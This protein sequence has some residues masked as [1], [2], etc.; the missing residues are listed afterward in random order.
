MYEL[1][2]FGH[3][4]ETEALIKK[5]EPRQGMDLAEK[6][7]LDWNE[8]TKKWN[9]R[10]PLNA[11]DIV[12]GLGENVRGINKRGWEYVSENVDDWSITE[13]RRNLYSAHNF[14][15]VDAKH[16][17]G[18]FVD[19]PEIVR[20]DISYTRQDEMVIEFKDNTDVL[21]ITGA[22]PKEIAREFR[23]LIGPSWLPPLFGFGYGQSRWEYTT[24]EDFEE[25]ANR[26]DEHQL[27]VDMI[28]M[29]IDYM[30]HYKDF[31]LNSSFSDFK[32][33]VDSF[34]QRKL[35]LIPII[36]AGIKQEE[37]YSVYEEGVKNNYFIKNAD[38]QS[39][40][41]GAA[42]PGYALFPDFFNAEASKWFGH[43]YKILTDAGI[44]GFW[45]DMNEPALFYSKEGMDDL[46]AWLKEF[47][48]NGPE[49]YEMFALDR[50]VSSI[51]NTPKDYER[52]FHRVN[53]EWVC[54]DR[55]HNLYGTKMTQSAA[56]A[57][58]Q[59]R[60]DERTLLFS[61]SSYI[62]MHR[63][64]GIWT[65]DNSSWWSHILLILQQLPGLSMC[66]FLYSGC[67]LGGHVKDCTRDLLLRF[68]QL[69]VFTPLMRNH[70]SGQTQRQ[71]PYQFE[72]IEDFRH[73][74]E[75]RYRLIPWLYSEFLKARTNNALLFSPLS[76]VWEDL[77]FACQVEDQLMIGEEVMIA[78]V[79]TQNAKG[80]MVWLPEEMRK[81]VMKSDGSI[82]QVLMEAG[83]HYV[84]YGLDELV[85][86]LRK[87]A[88]LPLAAPVCRTADLDLNT[89][90]LIGAP[91][92][93]YELWTDDGHSINAS[94]DK[95]VLQKQ[96]L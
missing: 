84:E 68:M 40:F 89:L 76:F 58:D 14:L 72:G 95:L 6:M 29:D 34:K 42:W 77:D 23:Q 30:D 88:T 7:D 32:S 48:Q 28:Y 93:C 43:Q 85:F 36:D 47:A 27:P 38:G 16:P 70:S 69:G 21:L 57:L 79:Y 13:D 1:Y 78:P 8:A 37:G 86:F 3:P 20:F 2:R 62:G 64:S 4:F 24:P 26:F 11:N 90:E 35:H 56:Q 60:P 63:Y 96:D 65:G 91:N 31:T 10:C 52:M 19:S 22:S 41:I 67:D 51:K 83:H 74:L 59:I 75:C 44:D 17:F 66:G 81:I 25:I 71:E 55:L 92:G 33:F 54:H 80:R 50:H 73:L 94:V 18:L 45:N 53:G 87:D 15:I 9:L 39:D 5:T 61:R 46:R 82:E 12:Y 49:A